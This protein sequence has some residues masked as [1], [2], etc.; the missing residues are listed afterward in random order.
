MKK[1]IL[2]VA[3]LGMFATT[4]AQYSIRIIPIIDKRMEFGFHNT[5]NFFSSTGDLVQL[6]TN[7]H[8]RLNSV[9]GNLFNPGL[10]FGYGHT[11][12]WNS[13]LISTENLMKVMVYKRNYTLNFEEWRLD[14]PEF[15][16]L[17]LPGD[18]SSVMYD[19]LILSFGD[20]FMLKFHL[21][22]DQ[23]EASAGIFLGVNLNPKN[24]FSMSFYGG[25]QVKVAYKM[26]QIY[27]A[28]TVGY[29]YLTKI[30]LMD[31]LLA[32]FLDTDNAYSSL[33]KNNPI[34]FSIGLGYL[35]E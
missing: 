27:F 16:D 29:D 34:F 25:P 35:F 13:S 33:T 17:A 19:D 8:A 3:L 5:S 6:G 20:D 30:G 10:Y 28:A 31:A 24:L 11:R 26:D 7:Y 4:F 18:T 2:S 14:K 21:M 9:E 22:D 1:F 23:L 15:N 32:E 12:D